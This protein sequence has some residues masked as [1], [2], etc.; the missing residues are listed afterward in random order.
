MKFVDVNMHDDHRVEWGDLTG[1]EQHEWWNAFN[2]SG[3]NG[4][5]VAATVGLRGTDM[6]ALTA[7]ELRPIARVYPTLSERRPRDHP[8]AEAEWPQSRR[9]RLFGPAP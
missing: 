8:V 1:R 4:V 6:S 7:E 2:A 9:R 3:R 5:V